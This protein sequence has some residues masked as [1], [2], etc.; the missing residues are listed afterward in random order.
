MLKCTLTDGGMKRSGMRVIN[1]Q[2]PPK[3]KW[4]T[5]HQNSTETALFYTTGYMP[6][7]IDY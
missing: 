4:E 6:I 2:P 3:I 5:N 7:F 1:C